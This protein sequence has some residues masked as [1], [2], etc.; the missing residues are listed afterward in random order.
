MTL[1]R[2]GTRLIDKFSEWTGKFFSWLLLSLIFFTCFEVITRR[3]FGAPTIW[4]LEMSTYFFSAVCM[5]ALGY[6]QKD[7][8]HVNVDILYINFSPKTQAICNIITFILFLGS[9]SFILLLY[10]IFFAYDSI[11][12]QERSPSAFYAL[13]WP[14]KLTIP[15]GAFL[16][17]IQALSD[18]IKDIVF[19]VKGERI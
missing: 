13:V 19:L 11:V 16:I 14:S 10:G 7:K 4:T 2:T 6:T 3:I 18:F 5:L 15:V 9:F 12:I 1:I 8:A 17:F